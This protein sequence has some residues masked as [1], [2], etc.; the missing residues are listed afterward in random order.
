MSPS[1]ACNSSLGRPLRICNFFL[2]GSWRIPTILSLKHIIILPFKPGPR[3]KAPHIRALVHRQTFGIAPH[4]ALSILSIRKCFHLCIIIWSA[5]P[6]FILKLINIH[7]KDFSSRIVLSSTCLIYSILY[8]ICYF[9]YV[10]LWLTL[11]LFETILEIMQIWLW[12][13]LQAIA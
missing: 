11:M 7:F 5:L 2:A 3:T 4:Q 10:M 9:K 13:L 6:T 8:L 1:R 12:Y